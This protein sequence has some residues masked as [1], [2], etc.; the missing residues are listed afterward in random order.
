MSVP[1]TKLLAFWLARNTAAPTSSCDSPKRPIDVCPRIAFARGV[2]L[3]GD[4]VTVLLGHRRLRGSPRL[5]GLPRLHGVLGLGT[6]ES[7][8]VRRAGLLA[9]RLRRQR[10]LRTA[11]AAERP[12]ATPPTWS[13]PKP[14]SA[15]PCADGGAER[16]RGS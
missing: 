4:I 11:A 14:A 3:H 16:A 6:D 2:G 10:R 8:V 9:R 12:S 5:G 1:V 15:A 7:A 13:C